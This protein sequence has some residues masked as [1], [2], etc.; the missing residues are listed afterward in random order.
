LSEEYLQW[1]EI[2]KQALIHNIRQFGQLVGTPGRVMA[3]VKANAYGHGLLEVSKIALG[4]GIEWLGV[5]SLEEGILLRENGLDSPVLILGYVAFQDLEKAVH[6][7]LKLTIYNF[8]TLDRL[9]GI[10]KRLQKKASLHLKVETGT[11][12]QGIKEEDVIPFFNEA[13]K[14]PNIEIEGISS[15]FSN[16]EDTTDHSYARFQH[17]NYKRILKLLEKNKINVPMRHMSCSAAAILFPETYFEMVR[18]GIGMYGLWPSKE[19]YVSCLMEKRE[20]LELK[21]V[22]SWKTKVAQIKQIPQGAFIGYGCT[23]KTTR[24]TLLAVLPIGYA[25]GY[26]RSLSNSAHVLIKGQRAPLRGRVAMN[27]IVVDVTDIQG[28]RLEEEAVLIGRDG[29]ESVSADD[30]AALTG[31]INYEIVSRINPQIPRLII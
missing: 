15:H 24:D 6:Q 23:F 12:R 18:V 1:V 2:D 21:P 29:D 13:E 8:E 5:H 28:I 19:T 14:N 17:E 30:M 22:L 26:S 4:E 3:V 16:I 11:Y 20:P 10:T 31:S 25:D 9:M 7:D 27:F